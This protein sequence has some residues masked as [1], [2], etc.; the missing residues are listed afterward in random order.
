MG[1]LGACSSASM[2]QVSPVFCHLSPSWSFPFSYHAG[3]LNLCHNAATSPGAIPVLVKQDLQ[4]LIFKG[5]GEMYYHLALVPPVV[6]A[7]PALGRAPAVSSHQS[8]V[9]WKPLR[10]SVLFPGHPLRP[11]PPQKNFS[12]PRGTMV[13]SSGYL[14]EARWLVPW[15]TACQALLISASISLL[16]CYISHFWHQCGKPSEREMQAGRTQHAGIKHIH[17]PLC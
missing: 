6:P 17:T 8:M 2:S 3:Q 4:H 5:Q 12:L 11:E 7:Y 10:I 14:R 16:R 13:F 15:L 1:R 9:V